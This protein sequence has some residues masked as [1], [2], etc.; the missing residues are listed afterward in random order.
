MPYTQ[1][2]KKDPNAPSQPTAKENKMQM[3]LA[4]DRGA[5][6]T[7]NKLRGKPEYDVQ[8]G[9]K[10]Y[11][12]TN[13][14]FKPASDSQ[15]KQVE[16]GKDR[17][18]VTSPSGKVFDLSKEEY[19]GA[20]T[21]PQTIALDQ[22]LAKPALTQGQSQALEPV[23]QSIAPSEE[24][25]SEKSALL[26]AVKLAGTGAVSGA[27]L[28]ALG[29][30]IG[31]VVV[32]TLGGVAG[33]I[34]GLTSS[35]RG[36]V[37][38]AKNLAVES[39]GNMNKILQYVKN[40]GDPMIARKAWNQQIADIYYAEQVLKKETENDLKRFLSG[41]SDELVDVR[42]T[43]ELLPFYEFNWQLAI[44]NPSALPLQSQQNIEVEGNA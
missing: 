40:G 1:K 8:E 34:T 5:V 15:K 11:P 3:S 36:V 25:Q 37:K 7:G 29:G 20:F 38:E 23:A 17:V 28:G 22:E 26:G 27:T 41:G 32:G 30:P 19:T 31:S 44:T 13:P 21:T 43:I 35:K 4:K 6:P 24:I 16:F 2:K 14:D 39:E 18:K 10:S 9:G 12:T 42:K 33:F